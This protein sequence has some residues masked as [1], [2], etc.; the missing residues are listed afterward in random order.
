MVLATGTGVPAMGVEDVVVTGAC[1]LF[2]SSVPELSHLRPCVVIHECFC[3]PKL[4]VGNRSG[5]YASE[6]SQ[7]LSPDRRAMVRVS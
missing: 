7:H 2:S 4:L 6:T 5:E 3:R 1:L